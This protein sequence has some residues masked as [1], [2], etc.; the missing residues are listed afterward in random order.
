MKLLVLARAIACIVYV[1]TMVSSHAAVNTSSPNQPQPPV[2]AQGPNT[3]QSTE[4]IGTQGNWVK[5]REWLMKSHEAF[6]EIQ[7]IVT[8]TEQARV[9]F[10][11]K[12][13]DVDRMLD[14]YY[15][16]VGFADGKI[17]ELLSN[18]A[19]YLEKK[20]QKDLAAIGAT[21][22][23]QDPTLQA[24]IDIIESNLKHNSQQLE[25][26]RLDMKA[27][28]D[29]GKS[30]IERVKRVDER[31]INTQTE[32]TKAQ[33]IINDLWDIIDHNKARDKYYELKITILEKIKSEQ[34]YLKQD[35]LSDFDVVTQTIVTQI[36]RTE[37]EI[38]KIEANGLFIK[39]RAQRIKELKLKEAAAITS[40]SSESKTTSKQQAAMESS[41][42]IKERSLWDRAYA[43]TIDALAWLGN[44]LG[45]LKNLIFGGSNPSST[46]TLK[47]ST[48]A[49]PA[50]PLQPTANKT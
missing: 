28:E 49:P 24:K 32:F 19:E 39:N 2:A 34:E 12:L 4:K 45:W 22:E 20:R 10:V 29:L 35:L 6:A 50:I 11:T 41:T 3:A 25:Q 37:E 17:N 47:A 40:S 18:I 9:I 1:S 43:I 46:A 30:L 15:K 48:K 42:V 21:G 16:G 8:Q 44:T 36:A 26:L 38:K 7:E 5:K 27:I 14:T 31:L 23:K 13:N 33:N